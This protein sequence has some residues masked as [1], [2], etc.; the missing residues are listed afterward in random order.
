MG[1]KK[2][3]NEGNEGNSNSIKLQSCQSA[4]PSLSCAGLEHVRQ[5]KTLRRNRSSMSDNEVINSDPSQ[6]VSGSGGQVAKQLINRSKQLYA[7]WF[8]LRQNQKSPLE[9]RP[10]CR[11][12]SLQYTLVEIKSRQIESVLLPNR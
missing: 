9:M 7:V 6:I 11:N 4:P 5:G 1:K 2:T 8:R 10:L 3:S 12:P